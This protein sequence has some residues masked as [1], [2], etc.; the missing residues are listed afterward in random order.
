MLN[1]N[2]KGKFMRVAISKITILFLS[3]FT[4]NAYAHSSANHD[5]DP[6]SLALVGLGGSDVIQQLKGYKIE[7]ERD[8]YIMG[9]NPEPGIG[10]FRISAPI[11]RTSHNLEQQ[12]VRIGLINLVAAREGGY[13]ENEIKTLLLGEE[14][15]VS[16]N[17]IM[18]IVKEKDKPLSSDKSAAAM[19]TERLLNPHIL[20]KEA[21]KD[22]NLILNQTIKANVENG[23]RYKEDEVMPVTIDRVRQS[24]KRTLIASKKWEDQASKKTFY[25][26]MINKTVN[27]P[28]WFK[29]WQ[30][31]TQ[32]DESGYMQLTIKNDVHP[33][34]F[35]IN[36]ETSRIDKLKTMEWDVIY[37]DIELEVKYDD[38]QSYDGVLFPMKV[39]M[40]QGGAPRLEITRK[41]IE[42]NP[43]YSS[44]HFL[45][46]NGVTYVHDENSAKRGKTLSQTLRMFTL[47]GASR[48]QLN[49]LK[50]DDGI[51]LL[52]AKPLDG[53]YTMVVEQSNGLVVIEPGMNDL[54]GEEVIKWAKK[55][56]PKKP[57]THLISTHH[58]NDH[59]G[60]VRPYVAAGA[61][62]VVHET[63]REFYS[64][65]INRPKSSIV[66]DALDRSFKKGTEKIIGVTPDLGYLIE[67]NLQP[68]TV[69]PVLNGHVEDMVI[70]VI[71]NKKMLYAG[72]L[73]VSGIARDKRSGT[74]RGPNVVPYHSAISLNKAII[75]FTIPIESLVGS[76]D[77]EPV[78][79][80]DL[81]DYITD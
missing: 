16:E 60:G 44:D 61:A 71:D 53:I 10:M 1:L 46:P 58:H 56:Y 77:K 75:K 57:I 30:K 80:K 19:R 74:K 62:L 36:P 69:Y 20:I 72:D 29:R 23:W 68:I 39:R 47:S 52:S 76:H 11:Y 25:P 28:D 41:K 8:E 22:S 51:Y 3:F 12:F 14:G 15:Y 64:M 13:F 73:Y 26:Q 5:E 63:A 55:K 38:W 37:G 43:Q 45:P 65:Q 40:S 81:I 7:S 34:T 59:G 27:D 54:K 17:D 24:G 33:I 18:G 9:Q 42:I 70:A 31:S 78:S 6:L 32:I 49:T 79:Y 35:F 67:D 21:L 4:L 48:P 50:L 2:N 66:I